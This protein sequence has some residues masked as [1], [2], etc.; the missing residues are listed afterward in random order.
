MITTPVITQHSP[1]DYRDH[2][3]IAETRHEYHNGEIIEMPG[4]SIDHNSITIELLVILSFLLQETDGD[5]NV[6]GSDLRIWIPDVNH[7]VYP[8]VT[9]VNGS[10]VLNGDRTDEILNPT[11]IAEVLSP[12]TSSYD[13]GDKFAAYR[14][15][16]S[17]REYLL[18]EQSTPLVEHYWKTDDNRWHLEEIR[19]LEASVT[20]QHLPAAL[21]LAKLYRRVCFTTA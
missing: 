18:I 11:L 13:R 2:E 16:P 14:T 8:D 21:P 9:V 6:Y 19:D 1:Q 4:G 12:S 10:P 20:L 7:G 5:Y 17:F 15:I 3:A